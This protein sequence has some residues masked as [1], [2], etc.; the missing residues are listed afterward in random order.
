MEGVRLILSIRFPKAYCKCYLGFGEAGQEG[1]CH[2][3]YDPHLENGFK[4]FA[5]LYCVL[6]I[7]SITFHGFFKNIEFFNCVHM[8]PLF[9]KIYDLRD[10]LYHIE[11]ITIFRKGSCEFRGAAI[12]SERKKSP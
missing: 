2:S 7:N 11:N 6:I 5:R 9:I 12:I 4:R 10:V 1:V 8:G 3:S